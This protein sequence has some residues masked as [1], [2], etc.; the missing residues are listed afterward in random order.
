MGQQRNEGNYI[1]KHEE[2]VVV[3]GIACVM[4]KGKLT[5]Q[6]VDIAVIFGKVSM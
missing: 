6:H 3:S 4:V 5:S 1:K 2:K